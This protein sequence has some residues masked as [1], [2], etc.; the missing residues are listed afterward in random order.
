MVAEDRRGETEEIA[1]KEL[2]FPELHIRSQSIKGTCRYSYRTSVSNP[3][4]I[5]ESRHDSRR[6]QIYSVLQVFKEGGLV[7]LSTQS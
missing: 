1:A 5:L 7:N 4:G 3:V 2:R 6:L